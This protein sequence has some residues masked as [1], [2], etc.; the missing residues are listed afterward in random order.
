[1]RSLLDHGP[2]AFGGLEHA[3][4]RRERRAGQTAVIPGPVQSLGV[5][6]G[7]CSDRGQPL[8]MA[9]DPRGVVRRE[10]HPLPVG[11][12]QRSGTRPH[13]VGYRDRA[14]V[15][16]QPGMTGPDRVA[17]DDP[18][19]ARR[20][21]GRPRANGPPWS[22]P[23][24]RRGRRRRAADRRAPGRRWRDADSGPPPP[25]APT[26]R[27]T[28]NRRRSPGAT[29]LQ[30]GHHAG[31]MLPARTLSEL[32]PGRLGTGQLG[33]GHDVLCGLAIRAGTMTAS[34]AIL[35][36]HPC[37]R[38]VRTPPTRAPDHPRG[39]AQPAQPGP[40]RPRRCFRRSRPGRFAARRPG[41]P[42]AA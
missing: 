40:P 23:S 4:R 24:G 31:I 42:R 12:G 41:R 32:T 19:R 21:T 28:G 2:V 27:Q 1:M 22:G 10:P 3:R 11:T 37:R 36:G 17:S 8:R 30:R 35:P 5:L 9:P 16:Q 18:R 38:S 39:V 25:T 33:Q 13:V 29:A 7:E 26:R 34:P 6:A 15:V 20:T 14:D